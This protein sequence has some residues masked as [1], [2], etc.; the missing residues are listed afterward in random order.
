M[1]S[2][3]TRWDVFSGSMSLHAA[4]AAMGSAVA[5]LHRDVARGVFKMLDDSWHGMRV[6]LVDGA[7]QA[8][9]SLDGSILIEDGSAETPGSHVVLLIVNGVTLLADLFQTL[10]QPRQ[11]CDGLGGA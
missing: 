9:A 1:I 5:Q 10:Q 6:H 3:T 4:R 8:K 11:G 2:E 7:A